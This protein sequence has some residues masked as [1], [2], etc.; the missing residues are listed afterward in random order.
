[1]CLRYYLHNPSFRCHI[2]RAVDRVIILRGCM[3]FIRAPDVSWNKPQSICKKFLANCL[4]KVNISSQHMAIATHIKTEN[5][6]MGFCSSV[7]K[8]SAEIIQ[9]QFKRCAFCSSLNICEDGDQICVFS[10]GPAKVFCQNC[11]PFL[12]KMRRLSLLNSA[13]QNNTWLRKKLNS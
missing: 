2:I 10:M 12:W 6:R 8:L 7:G 5:G 1:M 13:F 9:K 11:E 4:L 3:K